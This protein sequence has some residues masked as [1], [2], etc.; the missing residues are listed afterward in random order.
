MA[1]ATPPQLVAELEP[2][3]KGDTRE[4]WRIRFDV[5]DDA[6]P[7]E[8]DRVADDASGAQHDV[9]AAI[10]AIVGK[11]DE[12]DATIQEQHA[13]MLELAGEL[14]VARAEAATAKVAAGQFQRERDDASAR[15]AE[16]QAERDA[17]RAELEALRAAP[18]WRRLFGS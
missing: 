16:L 9:S 17:A 8:S 5:S 15:A 18:W 14:G 2:R 4:H 10:S 11:L 3:T 13:K 6:S 12:R 1:E 7:F